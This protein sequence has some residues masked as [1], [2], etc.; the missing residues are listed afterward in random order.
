LTKNKT[1]VYVTTVIII[2]FVCFSVC[3]VSGSSVHRRTQCWMCWLC[4]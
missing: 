4:L 1:N 3:W 2:M